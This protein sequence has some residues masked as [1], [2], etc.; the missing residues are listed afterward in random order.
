MLFNPANL[1][2]WIF[3]IT[4]ILLFLFMIMLG[5][6]SELDADTDLDIEINIDLSFGRFLEWAGIGKVPL[7]TQVASYEEER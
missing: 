1:P 4:G 2:Y 5:G 7:I 6:E 3:L